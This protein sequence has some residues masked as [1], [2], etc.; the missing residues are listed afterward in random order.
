MQDRRQFFRS[1]IAGGSAF[2]QRPERCNRREHHANDILYHGP[3]L[4]PERIAAIV[5]EHPAIKR[6]THSHLVSRYAESG[7]T[8]LFRCQIPAHRAM[9][10]E[11][12]RAPVG[13]IRVH[14]WSVA[15]PSREYRE[16]K[17]ILDCKG[18]PR[19]M[20]AEYDPMT[21]DRDDCPDPPEPRLPREGE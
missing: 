18:H 5:A 20:S 12:V 6:T 21:D 2:T 16:P 8:W 17:E 10:G 19:P 7:W 14:C 4:I 11:S 15:D 3:V 9:V 13:A 1:L